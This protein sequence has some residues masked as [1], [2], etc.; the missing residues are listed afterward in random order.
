MQKSTQER[1]DTEI[2][3]VSDDTELLPEHREA[4]LYWKSKCRDGRL[5]SRTDIDPIDI[6]KILPATLLLDVERTQG[7]PVFR[8]RLFGTALVERSGV[9]LTGLTFED[10]F[11]ADQQQEY[12]IDAVHRLIE[13]KNPLGYVGHSM[14]EH[15][16]YIRVAGLILPLASD[17]ETVDVIFGVNLRQTVSDHI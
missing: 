17:G 14:V 9:D 10:A 11:P 3:N 7:S 2:F 15:H 8:F 16:Q 13:T 4:Y 5:P 6:P 1:S 12:F